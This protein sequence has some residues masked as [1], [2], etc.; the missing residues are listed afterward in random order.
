MPEAPPVAYKGR[1]AARGQMSARK[2]PTPEG[3]RRGHDE[4]LAPAKFE[5]GFSLRPP[6]ELEV[7][8]NSLKVCGDDRVRG[9][10]GI[11][12]SMVAVAMRM[13]HQQR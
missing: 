11:P 7:R 12:V 4:H 3:A 8:L 5:A 9:E 6:R 1:G 2:K 10:L 13:N